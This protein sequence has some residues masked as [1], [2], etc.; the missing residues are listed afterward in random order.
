MR[1]KIID[2]GK[3]QG[4]LRG[5]PARHNRCANF[6]CRFLADAANAPDGLNDGLYRPGVPLE[7]L[8][9]HD[10]DA[11]LGDRGVARAGLADRHLPQHRRADAV[12]R[13]FV[14]DDLAARLGEPLVGE[15]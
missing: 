2:R 12:L 7:L 9:Q 13:Q 5:S 4:I 15:R 11:A 3:T 10:I 6:C 8:L 14:G 1:R